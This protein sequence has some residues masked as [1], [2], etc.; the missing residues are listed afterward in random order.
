MKKYNKKLKEKKG[1]KGGEENKG[2]TPESRKHLSNSL[3]SKTVKTSSN[4]LHAH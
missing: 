4:D 1:N 3:S 2:C